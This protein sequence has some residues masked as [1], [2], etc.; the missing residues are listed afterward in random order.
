MAHADFPNGVSL[1]YEVSGEGTPLLLSPGWTLNHHLWDRV[2]PDIERFCRVIRYDPRGA[3]LSTSDPSLEYSAP[4]DAEDLGALLDALGIPSAHLVGHSKGARTVLTFAMLHPERTLSATAIGSGEPHPPPERGG[5][6]RN[7][8]HEWARAL[9]RRAQSEGV[10]AALET[11]RAG[12]P[13]GPV[14]LDAERFGNFKRAT[15]GYGGA[16]LASTTPRRSLDTGA[17]SERL[18]MPVLY[19]CGERDP[20]LEECRYA[21]SKVPGSTL[22]TI[23]GCGHFPPLERPEITARAILDFVESAERKRRAT[24]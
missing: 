6:A 13:L 3:G 21:H 12:G 18:T 5:A 16:D 17:L 15:R 4:A 24:I 14:R 19:L 22:E 1:Y 2:F 9:H 7:S 10:A 8:V 11:M 20:F 23:P